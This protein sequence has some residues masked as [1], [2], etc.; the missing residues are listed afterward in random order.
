MRPEMDP[1][2]SEADWD[3][4]V[5]LRLRAMETAMSRLDSESLFGTGPQRLQIVV[6]V[7]VMPPDF[8]NTER[9]RRLNPPG[10]IREWLGEAAD[11]A[12]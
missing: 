1:F 8:T 12:R 10:A 7:E 11:L 6:N 2:M 5:D 9:A 4:E 3:S